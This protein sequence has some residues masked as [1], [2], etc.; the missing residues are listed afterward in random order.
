MARIC[1]PRFLF[2]FLAR[3]PN[4]TM[5]RVTLKVITHISQV[6][7][8]WRD[9]VEK[10]ACD[11]AYIQMACASNTLDK[12]ENGSLLLFIFSIIIVL[13]IAIIGNFT[14]LVENILS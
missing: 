7:E 14:Y 5:H 8:I 2:A 9:A 1:F 12:R 11:C 3:I 13:I 4:A 6:K 10:T